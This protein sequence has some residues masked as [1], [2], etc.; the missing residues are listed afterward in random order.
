MAKQ[1]VSTAKVEAKEKANIADDPMFRHLIIE[2]TKYRTLTTRKHEL[3]TKWVA[4]QPKELKSFIP[5]TI[6][7]VS[8]KPGD[9]VD[10]GSLLLIF[11]AMKMMNEIKSEV[12]G[13]VVM[14]HVK[15]SQPV[16]YGQLLMVV[17]AL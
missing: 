4:P 11:E 17:E 2:G 3:R 7:K 12:A 8:V 5:G 16:E 13:R 15:N 1:K 10:A 6:I 9:K 14:I